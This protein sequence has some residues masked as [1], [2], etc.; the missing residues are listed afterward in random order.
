MGVYV[1]MQWSIGIIVAKGHELD[2][3]HVKQM[4]TKNGMK[5][6]HEAQGLVKWSQLH[7]THT[8]HDTSMKHSCFANYNIL[9]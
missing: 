7:V 6:P 4:Q 9:V 5:P 1:G 8:M 3:W 2:T